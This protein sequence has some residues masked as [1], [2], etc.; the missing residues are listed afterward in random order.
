MISRRTGSWDFG[1]HGKTSGD[2]LFWLNNSGML[3]CKYRITLHFPK[4][5]GRLPFQ[6]YIW[7][8]LTR[9]LILRSQEIYI[10]CIIK[11]CCQ[12]TIQIWLFQIKL[13]CCEGW[14]LSC[15]RIPSLLPDNRIGDQNIAVRA[16]NLDLLVILLSLMKYIMR[17]DLYYSEAVAVVVTGE[18]FDEGFLLAIPHHKAPC[19]KAVGEFS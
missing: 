11:T 1:F 12:K 15:L 14:H 9:K 4:F 10:S 7:T 2:G 13:N 5:H 6:I 17:F 3:S 18:P 19:C 16:L 8:S